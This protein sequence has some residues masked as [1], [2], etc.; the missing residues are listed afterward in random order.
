MPV[1]NTPETK[2]DAK[3][4][5]IRKGE[6]L[7]V[8]DG[9]RVTFKGHSHKMAMAGGPSSPLIIYMAFEHGGQTAAQE[10]H[11]FDHDKPRGF[12]W[13]TFVFELVEDRY[14]EWMKLSVRRK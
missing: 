2:P 7:E 1:T 8:L 12:E 6:T 5:E 11:V 3:T 14:D 10:Y 9:L 4:F 13:S